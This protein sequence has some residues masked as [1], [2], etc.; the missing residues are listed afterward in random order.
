MTM[1]TITGRDRH[2][3]A[4]KQ[5]RICRVLL[6]D[7]KDGVSRLHDWEIAMRSGVNGK[8]VNA[9]L[10]EM[11]EAG[12]LVRDTREIPPPPGHEGPYMERVIRLLV[13]EI[14]ELPEGATLYG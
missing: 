7:A 4:S 12:I 14:K 1:W 6:E 10:R 3:A 5:L 9:T 8:K 11:E 13:S 2:Y